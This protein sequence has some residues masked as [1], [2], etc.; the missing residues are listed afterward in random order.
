[1]QRAALPMQDKEK[2]VRPQA[3]PFASI[4]DKVYTA[5]HAT[6]RSSHERQRCTCAAASSLCSA[7]RS[8]AC[9]GKSCSL[10]VAT[11]TAAASHQCHRRRLDTAAARVQPISQPPGGSALPRQPAA[12]RA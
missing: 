3:H 8:H 11:R 10:D 7:P 12:A 9:I 4:I 2:S 1:M 5:C 6:S